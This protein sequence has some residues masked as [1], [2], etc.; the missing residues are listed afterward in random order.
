MTLEL[1]RWR[2]IPLGF[3]G[4]LRPPQYKGCWFCEDA[5]GGAFY[6]DVNWDTWVH[7]DCYRQ[8]ANACKLSECECHSMSRPLELERESHA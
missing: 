8:H 2:A 4:P 1:V 5:R 7:V 3:I 6:F